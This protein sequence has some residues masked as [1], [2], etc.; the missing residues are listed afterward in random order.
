MSE[1][2]AKDERPVP[3]PSDFS[4]PFW[5]ATKERR[6]LLQ[7]CRDSGRYQFFPRPV[8][9]FTGRR[10]LEWREASGRGRLYT[11][12]VVH[13]PYTPAWTDHVPYVVGSVEL[14]EGVRIM[15][16]IVNCA[17]DAVTIGMRLRL[18][19]EARGE[20]SLPVFAPE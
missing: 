12:T 4:H 8:S 13:H 14:E 16:H 9:L 3:R 5:E 19:W 15:A 1:P 17:P 10:R 18:A 2:T 6:L 7:Y 11:F 20:F